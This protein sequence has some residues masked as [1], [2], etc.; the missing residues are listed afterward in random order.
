M[1]KILI[2]GDMHLGHVGYSGVTK[3]ARVKE[4]NDILN[5]IASSGHDCDTIVFL[6]DQFDR[7][8]NPSQVVKE[9]TNFLERFESQQVYI[10]AGNHEK[11]PS[12][13]SALDYLREIRG[14]TWVV[15]TDEVFKWSGMTF[16]PYFFKSEIGAKNNLDGA[17]IIFDK[18]RKNIGNDNN[19]V[20]FI[21]HTISDFFTSSGQNTDSF[22]E[23]VLNKSRLSSMFKKVFVG[24]IHKP[25]KKENVVM[26]GSIFNNEIN[27]IEKNIYK[28]DTDN[29]SIEQIKIP[30]RGIYKLE[31]PTKEEIG[32][33][34]NHN[35]LKVV[36]TDRKINISEI[37]NL[38][39]SFDGYM[40]VEQYPNERKKIIARNDIL[41][42]GVENLLDI[43]AKQRGV[44][45][46][47]LKNGWELVK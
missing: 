45:N 47:L 5:F 39:Q 25:Q 12:G 24:H 44:D 9:F 36:I 22:N 41:D 34:D 29:N 42:L 18:L 31:N 27:E 40:I 37:K 32:L 4:R 21:H 7:R 43:Y 2:I 15:V 35:I 1:S 30:G 10:L 46:I 17:D 26:C 13:D 8:N 11:N 38:L 23:I 20:L 28:Y 33:I 19:S 6:G 14:K 3:D 16:C